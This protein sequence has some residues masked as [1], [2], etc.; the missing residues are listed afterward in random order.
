MDAGVH[1]S[2]TLDV[3]IPVMDRMT[4]ILITSR[5]RVSEVSS[6]L[7][8]PLFSLPLAMGI[9]TGWARRG[10]GITA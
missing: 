5:A 2:T 10:L 9:W 4:L 1:A 7:L 6:G 3:A 8:C